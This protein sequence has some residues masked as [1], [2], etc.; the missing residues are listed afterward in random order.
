MTARDAFAAVLHEHIAPSLQA[1]GFERAGETFHRRVERNWEV[2][3][4]DH[5][6]LMHGD[7]L[8]LAASLAVAIER[9]RGKCSNWPKRG[10]PRE[11]D[12]HFRVGLGELLTGGDVWWDVR[13]DT[14]VAMLGETLVEALRRYGLP[15]LEAR[16]SDER[17]CSTYLA[18]LESVAWWELRP[19]RELLRQLGP[20]AA[21]RAL[22]AELRRR[23]EREA[24]EG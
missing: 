12:C 4:V 2:I 7:H 22:D 14:D 11:R 6:Q 20:A 5:G 16:S 9:L 8:K 13:P 24:A 3:A 15:W 23:A 18:Q 21:R 1:E 10:R 19:L 17:L